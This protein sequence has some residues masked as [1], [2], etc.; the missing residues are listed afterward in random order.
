M[1]FGGLLTGGL[2][3]G[4]GSLFGGLFGANAAKK[5]A[6]AE[7]TSDQNAQN[8][9]AQN[10]NKALGIESGMFNTEQQNEQPFLSAGQGAITSLSQLLQNGSLT[11]GTFKPPTAADAAAN[12][13]YQFALQQGEQAMQNSA[14]ARGGLL[15]GGTAEAL[16]NYAQGAATQNYQQVYNNAVQNYELGLQGQNQQ[17]NQ[18]AGV[19]GLGLNSAGQIG[20]VGTSLSGQQANTLGQGGAEQAQLIQNAG[21][22][23]AAGIVGNANALTS[24]FNN[25]GNTAQGLTL[26]SLLNPSQGA[27][28]Y[29]PPGAMSTTNPQ[30]PTFGYARGG[31]VKGRKP[32]LVGEEGPELFVPE[33]DGFVLPNRSLQVL[34]ARRLASWAKARRK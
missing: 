30:S 20:S 3:S 29:S 28:G 14:A 19:A 17:Y 13:G 11:P 23:Q 18:L 12:P 8:L 10:Q 16:N 7:V 5:A 15:T 26:A 32:I 27:S 24:M 22:A 4:V 25:L 34:R 1:P 6:N 21:Q 9:I 33:S 31:P 2:I